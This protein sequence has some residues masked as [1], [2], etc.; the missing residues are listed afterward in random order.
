MGLKLLI[1][2]DMQNDFITGA[3]GTKEAEAIVDNVAKYMRE[4]PG[5]VILTQDTHYSDYLKTQEGKKLPIPHCIAGTA[6]RDLH[7]NII[8]AVREKQESAIVGTVSK[9]TFGSIDLPEK[10]KISEYGDHMYD[11]IYLCG[12]CTDICVV[13]NAIILKAYYPNRKIAV[14]KDLCAGTTPE[15]HQK[16]LDVMNSCQIDIL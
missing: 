13:S 6:G 1:V 7:Y 8:A 2:V 9:N 4:F 3:L 12:L 11:E 5:D 15:N 14:L 16:A 10:I